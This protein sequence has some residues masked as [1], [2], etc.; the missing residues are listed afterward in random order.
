MLAL[1][2]VPL[3]RGRKAFTTSDS[4]WG[5]KGVPPN[6]AALV[7]AAAAA[8]P[9]G[10]ATSPPTHA[11]SS[12]SSPASAASCRAAGCAGSCSLSGGNSEASCARAAS[13]GLA[14]GSSSPAAV[15]SAISSWQKRLLPSSACRIRGRWGNVG[16]GWV[17]TASR[18]CAAEAR[19]SGYLQAS[20]CDTAASTEGCPWVA[21]RLPALPHHAQRSS[22]PA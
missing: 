1:R 12:A 21:R 18:W 4:M 17:C 8:L 10:A 16:A 19:S 6:S 13:V 3:P 9:A 15:L 14:A 7:A 5:W 20:Q 2:G 11:A 22:A